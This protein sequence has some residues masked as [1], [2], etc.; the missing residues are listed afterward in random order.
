MRG[1]SDARPRSSTGRADYVGGHFIHISAVFHLN[2][3][4][5]RGA[6]SG[7]RS[8]AAAHGCGP[9][10]DA[11]YESPPEPAGKIV[12][13]APL[14]ELAASWTQWLA[15]RRRTP[16]TIAAYRSVVEKA[17]RERGW[18]TPSDLT[19][20]AIV[21]YLGSHQWRGSTYTRNLRVF[22][23]LTRF[24][25]L[26]LPDWTDP[27][28][29][30]LGAST[31]DSG[32]GARAATIE[33]ARAIIRTA[34]AREHSDGRTKAARA[35]YWLCMFQAGCRHG[36]PAEWKWSDL[37]LD[38]E[39]PLVLWGGS[40]AQHKSGKRVEI[41]LHPELAALLREHRRT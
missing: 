17:M 34:W 16:R 36:E 7:M 10:H 14:V 22:Q 20:A 31:R 12:P 11:S 32:D 35:L 23:S 25:A 19:H 15:S 27:L 30:A 5:A 2:V 29:D 6:V 3:V 4:V 33:E 39:I 28:A 24:L 38:A 41:P 8:N 40:G 13:D 18:R 26:T 37:E 1:E 21:E 9:G